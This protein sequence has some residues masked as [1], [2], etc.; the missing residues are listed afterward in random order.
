MQISTTTCKIAYPTTKIM[1]FRWG[2]FLR[3]WG[4]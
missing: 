3:F 4:F 1:I 2:C